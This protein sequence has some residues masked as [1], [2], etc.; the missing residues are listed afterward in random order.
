MPL[1]VMFFVLV[2]FGQFLFQN[3]CSFATWLFVIICVTFLC[4]LFTLEN[5]QNEIFCIEITLLTIWYGWSWFPCSS[6]L[7]KVLDSLSKLQILGV[8]WQGKIRC[9]SGFL[10]L[11]ALNMHLCIY[12]WQLHLFVCIL[13][14]PV[15]HKLQNSL[16]NVHEFDCLN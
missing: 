13:F 10:E 5:L 8:Y 9:R 6:A 4:L 3:R 7:M 16:L 15:M 2:L 11:L 12:L 14:F 1:F